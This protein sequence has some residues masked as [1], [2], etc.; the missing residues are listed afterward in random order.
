MKTQTQQQVV[1]FSKTAAILKCCAIAFI[2][3]CAISLAGKI[4]L[5]DFIN[6]I[7]EWDSI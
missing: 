3:A 7:L 4:S 6:N 2:I 1:T 5:H